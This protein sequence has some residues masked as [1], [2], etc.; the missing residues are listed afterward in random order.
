MSLAPGDDVLVAVEA[1]ACAA[2]GEDSGRASV[3]FVGVERLDVLRFGPDP[4]GLHRYLTLGMSRRPMADPTAVAVDADGPR[5]EL[6]LSLRG[7]H[8]SV[9]GPLA[10]LAATPAVEGVVIRP[11]ASLSLGVPLWDGARFSAVLVGEPGDPVPDLDIGGPEPVR[12]LPITPVTGEEQAYKRVHGPAALAAL[13]AAQ[14]V[15]LTDPDRP[16]ARLP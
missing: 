6:L 12:F 1:H 3:S 9:L 14:G 5:A 10:L 13:W 7:A 2:L 8:D 11:G 15:D 16:A 4:D